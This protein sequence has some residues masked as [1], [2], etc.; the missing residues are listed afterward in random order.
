MISDKAS[1]VSIQI[2]HVG[3]ETGPIMGNDTMTG[4]P[5]T[6]KRPIGPVSGRRIVNVRLGDWQSGG[7]YVLRASAYPDLKYELTPGATG[8]LSPTDVKINSQG[9]R[10]PEPSSSPSGSTMGTMDA[11]WHRAE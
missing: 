8:G 5:M 6:P 2:R 11:S 4:V 1:R 9:F 7:D 10:G 3:P